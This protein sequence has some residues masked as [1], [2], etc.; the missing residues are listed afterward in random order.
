MEN[1]NNSKG[2]PAFSSN[3]KNDENEDYP[4]LSKLGLEKSVGD[5]RYDAQN[6]KIQDKTLNKDVNYYL[7]N[8]STNSMYDEKY[9]YDSNKNNNNINNNNINNKAPYNPNEINNNNNI[10]NYN[11]NINDDSL[12]SSYHSAGFISNKKN[13]SPPP[14]T[15]NNNINNNYPPNIP[16]NRPLPPPPYP[17]PIP[18]PRIVGVY[19]PPPPPGVIERMY[20]MRQPGFGYYPP[21]VFPPYYRPVIYPY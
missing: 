14:S 8:N 16:L 6:S 19:P 7:I 9:D 13:P 15:T 18:V 1:N 2:F 21:P 4:S 3:M 20:H 5:T 12:G 11:N 17:Y 10:P